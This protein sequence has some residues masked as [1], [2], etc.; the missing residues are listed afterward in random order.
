[1]DIAVLLTYV[2][3]FN[4]M[5]ECTMFRAVRLTYIGTSFSRYLIF[6]KNWIV[7]KFIRDVLVRLYCNILRFTSET[8]DEIEK[9]LIKDIFA[10]TCI[11]HLILNEVR[12]KLVESQCASFHN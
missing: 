9:Y 7:Y 8:I 2:E 5:T 11:K 6:Y 3:N 4:E 12:Y 10:R 1:M